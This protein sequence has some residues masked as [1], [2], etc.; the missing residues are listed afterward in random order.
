MHRGVRLLFFRKTFITIFYNYFHHDD[1]L[2]FEDFK[3]LRKRNMNLPIKNR[4]YVKANQNSIVLII[5][6]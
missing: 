2:R 5:S 6:L 4:L 1:D 3:R